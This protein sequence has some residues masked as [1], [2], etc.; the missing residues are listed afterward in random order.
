[1]S[2]NQMWGLD[3]VD[4]G[5]TPMTPLGSSVLAHVSAKNQAPLAR[6]CFQTISMGWADGVKGGLLLKNLVTNKIIIRRTFKVMGPG[7]SSLYDSKFDVNIEVDEEEDSESIVDDNEDASD[8]IPSLDREYIELHRNSPELKN[9]SNYTNYCKMNFYDNFDKS[10]WKVV[11][12][13]KEN[14]SKGPGSRT[15]FFKYYDVEKHIGGPINDNDFEYTPCAELLKD[16]HIDWD[17]TKNRDGIK[18]STAVSM[19]CALRVYRVDFMDSSNSPPPKNLDEARVHPEEGYFGAFLS[20]TDGFHKRKADV[21]ADLDIK[22][23]SP[24]DTLQLI[25]ILEKKFAGA[26]V[27]KFKCRVVVLGSHWKNINSTDT[28]ASMVGVDT[29]KLVLA[30]GA[31]L[32]MDMVK[33]DIKEAYLSTRVD[34]PDTYYTRRPPGARNGEMPYIV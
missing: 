24:S 17:D 21:P 2:R 4:L 1:M 20:E 6:K 7:D 26:N 32:D 34:E 8:T 22:D 27:E 15:P 16:K 5:A 25:P 3:K 14:K 11:A 30:L 33:F 10:Y 9:K 29:L 31:S 12:V 18:I 13:V 23:T 19:G 28:S